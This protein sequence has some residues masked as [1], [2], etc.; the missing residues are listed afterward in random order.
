MI[1]CK[2]IPLHF[3]V[4]RKHFTPV[5]GLFYNSQTT[6]PKLFEPSKILRQSSKNVQLK[7]RSAP[8][9]KADN[10]FN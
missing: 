4:G 8:D 9:V 1:E 7:T 5:Q 3:I 6:S 10:Y 2:V